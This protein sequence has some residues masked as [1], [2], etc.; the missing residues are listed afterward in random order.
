MEQVVSVQL[1]RPVITELAVENL[2]G[3]PLTA[4]RLNENDAYQLLRRALKVQAV[5][6]TAELELTVFGENAEMPA[7]FANRIASEYAAQAPKLNPEIRIEIPSKARPA[8]LPETTTL[9]RNASIGLVLAALVALLFTG[10]WA[11]FDGMK[12]RGLNPVVV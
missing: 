4:L 8:A 12:A 7:L 1:L 9:A 6:G 3:A 10:L 5:P 11:V 2:F